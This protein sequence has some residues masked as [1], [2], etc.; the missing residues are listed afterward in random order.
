MSV[1]NSPEYS[2]WGEVQHCETLCAGA[3]QVSTASHGGVL[4][5]AKIMNAMLSPEARKCGFQEGGYLCFEEDCDAP[6]ALRELMDK[7]LFKAPVN[8]YFKPGEYSQI[9]DRSLRN[10]H[11]EY[12][13]DYVRNQ[14]KPSVK[15][16][17]K[18][19]PVQSRKSGSKTG[20]QKY[21]EVLPSR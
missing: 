4:G 8:D 18:A 17:L 11:T 12:W 21:Q 10:W 3:Y 2:P 20:N 15:A 14:K 7:G 16:Q 13:A 1:Y 5:S 19:R 9:I 6:V